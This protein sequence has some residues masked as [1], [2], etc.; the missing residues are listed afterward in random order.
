MSVFEVTKELKMRWL[1][2]KYHFVVCNFANLDMVGHTGNFEAAV[3][4]CE[5]V[6][7]CVGE[8]MKFVDK[9]DG[10]LFVTADHG[11]ADEMIDDT[12]GVHTAHSK[13][14]VAFVWYEKDKN[15]PE[16]KKAREI[17]RHSP[18]YFTVMGR[19]NTI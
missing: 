18:Y 12:G 3:R 10:R 8:V 15:L 9:R 6:D 14:P 19:S 2:N 11:N 1:S 5:A 4:A 16:L 13:N 7:A 17:R